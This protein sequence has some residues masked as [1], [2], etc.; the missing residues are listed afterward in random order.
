MDIKD[1]KAGSYK[2]QYEYRS[3]MPAIVD[4]DWTLSDGN[5]LWLLSQADR[6]LGELNAFSQLVPDVDYFIQMHVRKEATTSSRIEGTQTNIEE[7]VQKIENIDPEKRDD[8]VEVH[9][10]IQAM[11]QAIESLRSLPISGRLLKETHRT[12]LQGVRGKH[13]LPGEFRKSQNWIGGATLKSAVFIP[14]HHTDLPEL[15]ADLER[16]LND[17]SR[18]TPDLIKIGIAHYQFETIHPFLD[19]NGRIGR[20]LI[21]LYLVSNGLLVKPSLYL[22]AFFD[23]QRQLYYDNLDRVRTHN[24]LGQWL[25]F[26]LEGIRLTSESSIETFKAIIDLREKCEREIISLGKK[27]KLAQ[28]ALHLLY[29]RPVMDG[30]DFAAGL[31]VNIS[32]ALRLVNDLIRLGILYEST[33][34]KRNRVF[35]FQKYIELFK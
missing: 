2:Q 28:A 18:S 8:W 10:Y 22:S 17:K 27:A 13:K 25:K 32:T 26:F 3:F 30:Q 33:G 9:N 21:A 4:H 35:V 12:L 23:E 14:P 16:L 19:G 24:D 7:A 34:F 29:S 5:L 6:K 15:I 11:N 20:L 31:S 1:Y